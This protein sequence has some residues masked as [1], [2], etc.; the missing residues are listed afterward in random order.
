MKNTQK[1]KARV[2][3]ACLLTSNFMA[4]AQVYS[5][6]K[7][8]YQHYYDKATE[9]LSSAKKSLSDYAQAFADAVSQ[10]AQAT[11]KFLSD[12]KNQ[13]ALMILAEIAMHVSDHI[14]KQNQAQAEADRKAALK[15]ERA[16]REYEAELR[17]QE[18]EKAKQQDT[19]YPGPM[20]TGYEPQAPQEPVN[21]DP[22]AYIPHDYAHQQDQNVYQYEPIRTGYEQYE[23]PNI[24]P[25]AQIPE[26]QRR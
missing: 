23:Q 19:Y 17:R 5:S 25:F 8:F 22:F 26:E 12:P 10:G 15:A 24:D 4:Q 2:V 11:Y 16:A 9:G 14:D 20:R 1:Y 6:Q 21:I 7:P 3:L 18:R 13:R